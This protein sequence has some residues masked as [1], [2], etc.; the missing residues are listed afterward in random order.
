MIPVVKP[1]LPPLEE[2]VTNL[3]EI[4]RSGILTHNG[5]YVQKLET[6]L[7]RALSLNTE[8]LVAVANGTLAIQLA[9][10]GMKIKGEVITSAF[11]WVAT[12][13]AITWEGCT[14][15]FADVD[16]DTYNI[17]PECVR[18][19]IT[20]N[21]VAVVPVHT[22]GNPCDV[23][24]LELISREHGIPII[25]DAAHA[26]GTTFKRRSVLSYGAAS[27]VS[28]HA[29]KI[30]NTG[31]GGAVI[32]SDAELA[33]DLR[34]LR[35]FGYNEKKDIVDFG[36]NF[37]MSEINAALGVTMVPYLDDILNTRRVLTDRYK[38]NLA[39][40]G[41]LTQFQRSFDDGFNRAYFSV[42]FKSE[43]ILQKVNANLEEN[44]IIARRYFY[45]SLNTVYQDFNESCPI[46]ESLSNRILCLPLYS[47]LGIE[48]VDRISEI[49]LR[50]VRQF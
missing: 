10:R 42:V 41:E 4:W 23:E 34:R 3:R 29:T 13:S 7:R 36:T 49:V 30:I 20:P 16:P 32:T 11:S 40:L 1:F 24:A 19:L 45:P 35:F 2:Y 47:D 15:V 12:V 17:D 50:A 44:N 9:L 5:P 25:Y 48:Q 28:L 18:R 14:P 26:V 6:D 27:A 38:E 39:S 46:S 43:A 8:H 33:N 22:F 21:T 31:E 37:K